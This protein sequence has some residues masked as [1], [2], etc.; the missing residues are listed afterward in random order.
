M[1]IKFIIN[2]TEHSYQIHLN[3]SILDIK[4]KIIKDH[5][6]NHN[7]QLIFT[8]V[9]NK[10]IREFGK[11]NLIPDQEIPPTLDYLKI[12]N[13]SEADRNYIFKVVKSSPENISNKIYGKKKNTLSNKKKNDNI[14]I[15]N[16]KTIIE[17]NNNFSLNMADFPP[18]I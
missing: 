11:Y 6:N 4:N 7:I 3:E 15:T 12:S 18:L 16:N 13:F 8:F 5:F 9:G 1:L 14:I 17:N 2:D 10:P